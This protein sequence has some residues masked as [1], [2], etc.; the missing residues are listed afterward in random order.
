[1]NSDH[2]NF[3]ILYSCFY[4][5]ISCRKFGCMHI[6][7]H[8]KVRL[9]TCFQC[10]FLFAIA[11]REISRQLAMFKYNDSSGKPYLASVISVFI[12]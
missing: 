9:I 10:S 8:T 5:L 11:D 2:D 6:S 3:R 12:Q 4:L 7:Y 1:M